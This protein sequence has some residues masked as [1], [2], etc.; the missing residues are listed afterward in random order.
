MISKEQLHVI[1]SWMVAIMQAS[2]VVPMLVV[3]WRRKRHFSP[4]VKLLSNYVYLSA[5]FVVAAWILYPAYLPS[6][7]WFLAGFNFCKIILFW[8]VYNKVLQSGQTRR[9]LDIATVAALV[10]IIG[11]YWYDDQLGIAYCRIMQ[12]AVLA[13]FAMA[14]M[15]Q[16]LNGPPTQRAF[17]DPL[18]LVSVGQL[19]YSAGTVTAFSQDY[20]SITIYDKSWKYVMVACAGLAFNWF[21]TLA[22]LRAKQQKVAPAPPAPVPSHLATPTLI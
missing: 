17:H 11:V 3:I 6:N 5:I 16:T 9:V 14:Y 7:I 18:W 19:V 4:A 20:L 13:A 12:C 1:S 21:L 10:S 15:E 2:I 8:A 22:F